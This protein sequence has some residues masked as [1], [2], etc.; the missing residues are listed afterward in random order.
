[1]QE[2]EEAVVNYGRPLTF[3]P[4]VE[5]VMVLELLASKHPLKRSKTADL[6]RQALE[7]YWIRH[8][9]EKEGGKTAQ[10]AR[11]EEDVKAIRVEVGAVRRI[12][13]KNA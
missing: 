9:P 4:T 7:D 3:R 2:D 13:E 11:V 5:D 8:G 6:I 1:M 10:L 12:V